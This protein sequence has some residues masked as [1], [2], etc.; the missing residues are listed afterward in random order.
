MWDPITCLSH[1]FNISKVLILLYNAYIYIVCIPVQSYSYPLNPHLSRYPKRLCPL[2]PIQVD[3]Y[4]IIS[5]VV[6]SHT[7]TKIIFSVS[8]KIQNKNMAHKI[9]GLMKSYTS[10]KGCVYERGHYGEKRKAMHKMR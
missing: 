4:C 9:F 2:K 5:I 8:F 7:H 1:I 10:D 6:W 3:A